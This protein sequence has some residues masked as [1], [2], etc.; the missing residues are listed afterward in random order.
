M[1]RHARASRR[2]EH[3]MA[4]SDSFFERR[5]AQAVLKHGILTRYA[6]YFAGRAGHATGGR[7]AFIDGY[8]GEGR[9]EDGS[10]G[11]PLLLASEAERAILI[12]R[13]IRLAFVEPANA[14]R[15]RL[16][17]AL[18]E[19]D[20]D[21]DVIVG[22]LFETIVDRLLDRY[23]QRAVLIF[24]DPF[25]LATSFDTLTRVLRRSSRAQPIDVLYHFSLLTVAR[26]ARAA[27]REEGA[28]PS[29]AKQLDAALGPVDWRAHFQHAHEEGASTR[30]AIA[31]AH[32]F[33]T[34]VRAATDVPSL[35]IPVAHRPTHL[36]R[37]MLTLFSRDPVGRSLWDFADHAGKAYVDWL[38]HCETADYNANVASLEAVGVMTL[39][40]DRP[41]RS[42]IED[43]VDE[44]ARRRLRE[45]LIA[46]LHEEGQIVPRQSVE[47]TYGSTLGAAREKHVRA[48]LKALI[49]DGLVNGDVSG[50]FAP[51]TFRRAPS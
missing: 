50:T 26:V 42:R 3:Q 14:R 29:L 49:D 45:H 51:R 47:R 38:E 21:P 34:A 5:N 48:A 35:S 2:L 28:A 41:T 9:Y 11:S 46:V 39:F 8:A 36:P 27:V 43:M 6:Y 33:G 24:V 40:D 32:E 12:A 20:I 15:E 25:G 44:A 18:Q 1:G 23:R 13:D 31:V 4:A 10:P 17:V 7:V 30:A 37:Y 16:A 22:G 19:N